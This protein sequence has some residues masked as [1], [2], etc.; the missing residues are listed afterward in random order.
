MGSLPVFRSGTRRTLGPPLGDAGT[1]CRHSV[2]SVRR[3]SN[4]PE[5]L[6]AGTI[7]LVIKLFPVISWLTRSRPKLEVSLQV[8]TH[9]K[10]GIAFAKDNTELRDAVN[11]V[12]HEIRGNG[13]FARIQA[14]WFPK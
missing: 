8:P 2:L 6:E 9:E 3:N 12:L 7:G 11:R 5:R 4:R 1:D 14:R 13:E 10:L